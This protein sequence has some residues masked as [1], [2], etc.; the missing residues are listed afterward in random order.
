MRHRAVYTS[1]VRS[2]ATG[3]T[4]WAAAVDYVYRSLRPGG[5]FAFWENNPWNPAHAM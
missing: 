5:L 2:T 1:S 4:H 3:L